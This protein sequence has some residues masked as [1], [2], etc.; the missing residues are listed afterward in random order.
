MAAMTGLILA[1]PTA[2]YW[3]YV[4]FE[5][6][7]ITVLTVSALF[8]MLGIGADDVFLMVDSYW[9]APVI[10]GPNAHPADRMKWAYRKA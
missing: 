10:L 1:F 5:I 6:K 7:Q 9:Q 8:V 2:Y 3:Y 4:H